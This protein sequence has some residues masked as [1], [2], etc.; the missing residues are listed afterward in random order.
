[1][2]V[3]LAGSQSSEVVSMSAKVLPMSRICPEC[4]E[5]VIPMGKERCALCEGLEM[6]QLIPVRSAKPSAVVMF[7]PYDWFVYGAIVLI[8]SLVIFTACQLFV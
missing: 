3:L 4:R 7:V 1:V 2:A 8:V 6:L 5:L